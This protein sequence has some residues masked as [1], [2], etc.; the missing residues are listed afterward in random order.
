MYQVNRLP[1][2]VQKTSRYGSGA[3]SKFK[4]MTASSPAAPL[5]PPEIITIILNYVGDKRAVLRSRLIRKDFE[6]VATTV[7]FKK[8]TVCRGPIPNLLGFEA[9]AASPHL[10]YRV[11]EITF[12][13]HDESPKWD[14]ENTS[15]E[16]FCLSLLRL[17]QFPNLRAL[18]LHFPHCHYDEYLPSSDPEDTNNLCLSTGYSMPS[19][20]EISFPRFLQIKFFQKI[21]SEGRLMRP[22]HLKALNIC[23][24][25]AHEGLFGLHEFK[26]L[27]EPLTSLKIGTV[28][29]DS[30]WFH[31]SLDFYENF[32]NINM[33]SALNTARNLTSLNLS[34]DIRT[35]IISWDQVDAIPGLEKLSFS[36]FIFTDYNED[37]T[38]DSS[39]IE[40]F[41][42]RH[43]NLLVLR[44]NDC[45][46]DLWDSNVTW[47]TTFQRFKDH[48][49]KLQCFDFTPVPEGHDESSDISY[50]Y[51]YV[52]P[53]CEAEYEEY[54]SDFD[55]RDAPDPPPNGTRNSDKSA[56]ESLQQKISQRKA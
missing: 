13:E 1:S 19:D 32:W 7:G 37:S 36:S 45:C 30:E 42:L 46:I 18:Q 49:K 24:L 6:A 41:I 53:V 12:L 31:Q 55:H 54:R 10:N 29:N 28:T 9:I 21:A 56:Y 38:P 5:L 3:D 4:N 48:L 8:L 33:R 25:V 11:E 14:P 26:W 15:I 50:F 39:S 51:S 22:P 27:L 17:P 2:K 52:W 35:S 16:E 34:S 40:S 20:I 43:P 23:P 47:A 44:L